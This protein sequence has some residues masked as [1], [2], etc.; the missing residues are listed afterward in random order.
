M[1]NKIRRKQ[2]RVKLKKYYINAIT[3]DLRTPKFRQRRI[4]LKKLRDSAQ[5]AKEEIE[6]CLTDLPSSQQQLSTRI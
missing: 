3:R 1:E 5:Q 2:K 4:E 6:E